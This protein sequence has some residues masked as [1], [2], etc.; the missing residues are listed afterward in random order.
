[1]T[2]AVDVIRKKRDGETL[3]AAEI[4]WM[5]EG[6]RARRRRRLPVVG[7]PDGDP[8]AGDGSTRRPPP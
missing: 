1:M 7:A 5:V 2:R 3:S 4:D 6:L 8:L